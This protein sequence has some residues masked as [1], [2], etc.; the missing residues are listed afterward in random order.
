MAIESIGAAS[1]AAN[2]PQ[3]AAVGQD[4]FL[5]I[6]LTQLRFQ[7]PLKP[8]DNQE[9]VAQLAQ[10]SSLE[11]SRQ[12][13]ERIAALLTIQS[14]GQALSLIG[15]TVEVAAQGGNQVGTVSTIRFDNGSPLLTI[16]VGDAFLTDVHLAEVTLVNN[17]PAPAAATP[18]AGS[19]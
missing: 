16:K 17:T 6:L 15:R 5:K 12:Q 3:N 19:Q 10:F 7:D 1:L 9:F 4:D 13:N 11:F 14:A 18:A 2:A 8:I